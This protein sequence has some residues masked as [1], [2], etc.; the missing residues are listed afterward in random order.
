VGRIAMNCLGL[1]P[2]KARI[3]VR[4]SDSAPPGPDWRWRIET[5]T[6]DDTLVT[7]GRM[8]SYT[9][10]RGAAYCAR[11]RFMPE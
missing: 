9:R 2:A 11:Q 8:I 5:A 3:S 4:G 1:S 7:P 6:S 10:P